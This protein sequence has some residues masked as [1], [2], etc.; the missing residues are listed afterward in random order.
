[1]RKLVFW[2]RLRERLGGT[3]VR[4]TVWRWERSGAF[5]RHVQVGPQRIGWFED[6]IDAWFEARAAERETPSETDAA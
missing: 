5:P 4:S 6:E 1:M 3:T 2:P